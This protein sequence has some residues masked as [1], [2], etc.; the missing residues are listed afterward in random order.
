VR[1]ISPA[2]GGTQS[3]ASAVIQQHC[4]SSL[5]S[6]GPAH[7]TWWWRGRPHGLYGWPVC[8]CGP[9][10]VARA[11]ASALLWQGAASSH[12]SAGC[13][14]WGVAWRSVVRRV[15]PRGECV[16][17]QQLPSI[18]GDLQHPTAAGRFSAASVY[19]L[20]HPSACSNTRMHSF[21][22][23][24]GVA[25]WSEGGSVVAGAT[26][27][28]IPWVTAWCRISTASMCTRVWCAWGL[29]AASYSS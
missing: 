9:G 3:I 24:W 15:V 10:G 29:V 21:Q 16:S 17:V 8:L 4:F 18:R 2:A 11:G 25:G 14:R 22:V 5:Y 28:I 20:G 6:G 27:D 26:Q 1:C 19:Q 12:P 23:M 13:P 7:L